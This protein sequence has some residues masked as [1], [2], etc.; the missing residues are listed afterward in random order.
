MPAN[1]VMEACWRLSGEGRFR[2]FHAR[3]GAERDLEAAAHEFHADC[4][5][6]LNREQM[7]DEGWFGGP[8][9]AEA[10]SRLGDVALVARTAVAFL[11]PADTGETRLAAR[12]GSLTSA[13]MQV[14]LLAF[15]SG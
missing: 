6:V 11:D 7:I 14:P 10:A 5:W 15:T 8:L 3:P 2:W 4:A 1:E 12:H 13:E 9:S